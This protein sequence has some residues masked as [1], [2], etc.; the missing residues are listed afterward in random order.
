MSLLFRGVGR[1]QSLWTTRGRSRRRSSTTVVLPSQSHGP[2]HSLNPL[3]TQGG[4]MPM[5]HSTVLGRAEPERQ[6]EPLPTASPQPSSARTTWLPSSGSPP[7]GPTRHL[8]CPGR[9]SSGW[10]VG[11]IPGKGRSCSRSCRVQRCQ[12][13]L[14]AAPVPAP[15]PGPPRQNPRPRA[16]P[17]H[18]DEP[19]PPG[20][21]TNFIL[22]PP[23]RTSPNRTSPLAMDILQR[24]N[25]QL[26]LLQGGDGFA[27]RLGSGQGGDGWHGVINGGAA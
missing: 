25:G 13:T 15:H 24:S 26:P 16:P 1:Q 11:S 4:S 9:R 8:T 21:T 20:H 19:P 14:P 2:R 12:G 6:A 5:A 17:L 22:T 3:P 27:H 7:G 18:L 10:S 23:N